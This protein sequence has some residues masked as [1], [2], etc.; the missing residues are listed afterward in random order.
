MWYP[1]ELKLFVDITTRCNVGCPMCHRTNPNGCGTADWLPNIDWSLEQ[2]KKAYPISVCE[3]TRE[4][5]ICGTWGDPI[6][7]KDLLPIVKYIRSVSPT[8]KIVINT[9]GSL[10][11][12]E[13]WWELGVIGGKNLSVVFAVE[14]VN[15]EMHEKYRQKSFLSKILNNMDVLSN[16]QAKIMTQTIAFKHNEEYLKDIE[17]LCREHGSTHHYIIET[18]RFLQGPVFNFVNAKG[19]PETLEQPFVN[20]KETF[21]DN[22]TKD[23]SIR[24]LEIDGIDDI[25]NKKHKKGAKLKTSVRLSN[26]KPENFNIHKD[27]LQISCAWGNRNRIVINPDGQVLPCCYLC[28]SY[29]SNKVGGPNYDVKMA[30][31]SLMQKYKD[32]EFNVFNRNLLDIISDQWF[33]KDL[34][35]SFTSGKPIKQCVTFCSKNAKSQKFGIEND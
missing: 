18:N 19:E 8:S 29:F 32:K 5:N 35:D 23:E 22:E 20:F 21:K 12:E 15:Q 34:K 6:V 16:T 3:A 10:R 1:R 14:G 27:D 26:R 13:F 33:K 30:E 4:F 11:N 24:V 31:H 2:F 25:G 9:N 17:L 7:N 28:N